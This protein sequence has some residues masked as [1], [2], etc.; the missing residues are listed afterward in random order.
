[1]KLSESLIVGMAS[2]LIAMAILRAANMAGTTELALASQPAFDRVMKTHKLRCIAGA[3]APA[4]GVSDPDRELRRSL[5]RDIVE[6]MGHILNLQIEWVDDVPPAQMTG[7]LKSGNEDALCFPLW[8]DGPRAAAFDFTKP[9]D[10]MPVYAYVRADDARFD[11]DLAKIND[12]GVTIAVIEGGESKNIANEDFPQAP[13]YEVGDV[14]D[15]PHLLLA[16]TT[17]KAD[18]A[19]V[20]PFT[21]DD[22]IKN[23][24]GTL[25][26]VANVAPV[27]VFG[28]SFAVARGESKL[29]DMM[30]V[31]LAQMQQSG[32]IKATLDKYLADRK[33]EYFYPAKG[34]E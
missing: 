27:R 32:F 17:K 26:R 15:L 8:P 18:A 34:W 28:E 1:M 4:L 30:N 12:A 10:Y 3:P 21:G 23:N 14:I 13:Q 11:G 19:F 2:A 31:A 22:F 29:R 33:G 16:V 9:L 5:A 24:P 25:K 6:Q 7:D 20:D